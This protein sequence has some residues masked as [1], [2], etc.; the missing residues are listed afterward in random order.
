MVNY[1]YNWQEDWYKT[2]DAV[3]TNLSC[4]LPDLEEL[5]TISVLNQLPIIDRRVAY[6]FKSNEEARASFAGEI[7]HDT[8]R[9][10]ANST[11]KELENII[12][13]LEGRHFFEDIAVPD[14]I[15]ILRKSPLQTSAFGS[16]MAAISHTL[17]A[18][19]NSGDTMITDKVLYGCTDGF[20]NSDLGLKG[21]SAVEVD[22]SDLKNVKNTFKANPHAKLIYFETPANPTLAV[23]DIEG[24]SRIARDYNALVIVDNTF[25]TPYLQNPLKLGADIVVHSLTK[26]INGHGDC[27]GG[28][29]TGPS[30]FISCPGIGGLLRSRGNFGGVLSPD[31]AYNIQSGIQTISERMERHCDNAE[32]VVDYLS[33]LKDS[34]KEVYYPGSQKNKA[35]ANKQMHRYGAMVSFELV[36]DME[37]A[38]RFIDAVAH[39]QVGYNKVSLGMPQTGFTH[40]AGTTH[41]AIDQQKRLDKG[42]TPNLIRMSV[43]REPIRRIIETLE[44]SLWSAMNEYA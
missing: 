38:S 28:S 30:Q 44:A 33:K 8:Y 43:G 2:K 11:V 14:L 22:A 35:I 4:K 10:F 29:A 19:L 16:G 9:R 37:N 41:L 31:E 27:M 5:T 17:M 40:P 13:L 21:I 3:L 32:Q 6:S 36:G 26:Y 18:L 24:I 23:R 25:A 15:D 12:T 39:S 34:V 7:M 42:I 20:N 1:K